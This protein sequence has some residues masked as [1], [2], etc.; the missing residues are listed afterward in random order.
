MIDAIIFAVFLI[1]LL[2][3]SYALWLAVVS[4]LADLGL[5]WARN[6][7]VRKGVDL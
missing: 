4:T 3:G 1:I 6:Y 2:L 7:L 5:R